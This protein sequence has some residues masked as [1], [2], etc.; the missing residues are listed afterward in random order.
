M[1]WKSLIFEASVLTILTPAALPIAHF[2]GY[3]HIF[4]RK[5]ANCGPK[6]VDPELCPH[7]NVFWGIFLE[8][9][10]VLTHFDQMKTP[11]CYTLLKSYLSL[12]SFFNPP[13]ILVTRWE[14]LLPST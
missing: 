13:R 3:T 9:F 8:K 11:K 7:K 1:G 6:T 14:R 5:H 2:E 4:F 12:R 10:L